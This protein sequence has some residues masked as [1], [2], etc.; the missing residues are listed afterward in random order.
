MSDLTCNRVLTRLTSRYAPQ[1]RTVIAFPAKQSLLLQ[2]G[3]GLFD[4]REAAPERV[5]GVLER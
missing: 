4:V 5:R 1:T 2:L 3:G